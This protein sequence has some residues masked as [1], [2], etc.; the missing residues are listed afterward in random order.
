MREIR[1]L[2]V[3]KTVP[4]RT[5]DIRQ[6]DVDSRDLRFTP[7]LAL[8]PEFVDPR[9]DRARVILD[10]KTEGACVGF[11][12][13]AVI[14]A[15]LFR[16]TAS[17]GNP[18]ATPAQGNG[19]SHRRPAG[20]ASK[21][22]PSTERDLLP[23]LLASPRMLYE[24]ARRYDDWPGECY[25][26]TTLR[27]AMKGWHRHGVC[28]EKLWPYR[29]GEGPGHLTPVRSRNARRRPLGAYC[30][31][32]DDDVSHLQAAV[33]E[34][35]A[36]LASA[37]VH[38]GWENGR[39]RKRGRML[40][41]L[42]IRPED[43]AMG[44]H[45]FAIVGYCP[46]GF[47][48]QNSWGEAW[49]SRGLAILSYE[50]WME[51]RQDAWVARP[52][53][54]TWDHRGA[55]KIF[56]DGFMGAAPH[57]EVKRAGTTGAEGLEIDPR[58]LAYLVNT[59]DRGALS[60]DGRLRTPEE[61]LPAMAARARLARASAD[62]WRDIV[63]YAHGG[64]NNELAGAK[65]AGELWTFCRDHDLTAWFFVW[66]TGIGEALL[67]YLRSR[68]DA[69]GPTAG[70]TLG[71]LW[72]EL[73]KRAEKLGDKLQEQ[74]GAGLAPLIRLGWKEMHGRAAGAAKLGSK[75][76]AALFT[77]E[78]VRT[79][80]EGGPQE[81]YRLHLVAHSAGAIYMARLYQQFLRRGIAG[82]QGR[83]ELGSIAFMAPAISVAAARS[84]FAPDG[85]LPVPPERF[86]IWTLSPG[87]EA[88]DEIGIYPGSLL[89]YVADHLERPEGREPILGIRADLEA[90]SG[91]LGG[92]R[93]RP[94][95]RSARHAQFDDPGHEIETILK[96]IAAAGAPRG[97]S[98]S[99]TRQ[100]GTGR[101]PEAMSFQPR[102]PDVPAGPGERRQR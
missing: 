99:S 83:I 8:L 70:R 72:S 2:G 65:R 43:R 75:G 59:G 92:P 84:V 90:A 16:R 35:D 41:L 32:A 63:L 82:S 96:E 64:L 29:I 85:R 1:S 97:K 11:A 45:A 46:E 4:Y 66:E 18:A 88:N 55:P 33:V 101:R 36:V 58:A 76:G 61:D 56:V 102:D 57:P 62:G 91:S 54:E 24:M 73:E 80:Q 12:L 21:Q 31:I 77:S 42:R 27:A 10:Q 79:I 17:E 20:G 51:N 7:S 48:V 39:L 94:A 67:G 3:G 28:S 9:W 89:T 25:E 50:D 69:S 98:R 53:P 52:G 38:S 81:R 86:T 14:N 78:L 49:G 23:G 71:G 74:L 19:D 44:L 37:W 40:D 30:R 34:A 13:A 100:A 5:L 22:R 95:V 68:D 6:D 47:I 15:S 26:G 93:H 87:D 60:Q